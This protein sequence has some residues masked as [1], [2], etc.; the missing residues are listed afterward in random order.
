M[1]GMSWARYLRAGLIAWMAG[2]TL[3]LQSAELPSGWT[4]LAVALAA[5]ALLGGVGRAPLTLRRSAQRGIGVPIWLRRGLGLLGIAALG[6]S[7]TLA[8]A[9]WL[10]ERNGPLAA[11]LEAQDL[12]LV[13]VV[14]S[15]PEPSAGGWRFRVEVAQAWRLGRPLAVPAE[16][17]ERIE[18]GWYAASARDPGER[19][20]TLS[21]GVQPGVGERWQWRV[22]LKRPHGQSNPGG[23]D[24]EQWWWTQGVGAI[25]YVREGR[26]DP[27]PRRLATTGS[28]RL[29]AWR[30]AVRERLMRELAVG[31]DPTDPGTASR[32]G[33][34]GALTWGEQGLIASADWDL[35]RQTGVAHLMSI[36]GLHITL[37]AW[38]VAWL[39]L[40]C[41]RL[42]AR[43]GLWGAWRWPA[44]D[45]ARWSGVGAAALYAAFSG[46][47]VPSQ[48]T[49]W[50][51]VLATVLT[52]GARQWPVSTLWLAVAAWLLTLDPWALLQPGFWLSFVAVGLLMFSWRPPSGTKAVPFSSRHHAGA[53]RGRLMH[54]GVR[55]LQAFWQLLREQVW[56]SLALA[57]LSLLFFGQWSLV[58]LLAN[59]VAI[60]WVTLGVTPLCLLGVLWSPCWSLAEAALQPLMAILQTL[61]GWPLAVWQRPVPPWPLVLLALGAALTWVRP[62][63]LSLR[64]ALLPLLWPVWFW[65]AERPE[66]GRFELM[67][68]DVGQ[69]TAVL[70]R[71]AGHSLM[72]DT[73]PRYSPETDAGHRVLL[74]LLARQGERLD[75]VVLSHRDTDHTGGALALR[76]SQPQARWWVSLEP[77][78][79]LTQGERVE[80]CVRG[81]R[82]SWDGVDLEFLA[83][84]AAQGR[85]GQPPNAWSCVLR[86]SDA[87][88]HAAL[89][90]AD[91]EAAQERALIDAGDLQPVDWLMVPHHGSK[92]SSTAAFLQALRPRVAVAQAGYLNRHGH[93]APE[94]V[95]RYRQAGI[96]FRA[97]PDCGAATWR[98]AEPGQI[99]CHREQVRRYWHAPP[100]DDADEADVR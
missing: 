2:I 22:R 52:Q 82:W 29:E 25:A 55:G 88:G 53:W 76:Q 67:A 83:P 23:V 30:Q 87:Q 16:V 7:L 4:A 32:A 57:P 40:G 33:V 48:R 1:M 3:Q 51:L 60:P 12:D 21:P 80:P 46:W 84:F 93:P 85:P 70:L 24:A 59:L 8:H 31:P 58:G 42:G 65:Q 78:H 9:L 61:A 13:G 6:W 92:T 97:T 73:G 64:V 71:T 89:L 43:Q 17:P 34:V 28:H 75:A 14:A 86:V 68:V 45:V 38:W 66:P 90:T 41:W 56:I 27:V 11:E 95:A 47:G 77:G 81:Q 39:V 74:P 96:V 20:A 62:M 35:F 26:L 18:L 5:L 37:Q 36:S 50:M 69:G 63:P 19:L 15:L 91:I 49:V 98:S 54:W 99:L 10:A 72:Y 44:P 94:V 100:R 79:P